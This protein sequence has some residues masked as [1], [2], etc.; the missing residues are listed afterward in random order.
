MTIEEFIGSIDNKTYNKI[1]KS[2]SDAE[3]R[4]YLKEH[5]R[6]QLNIPAVLSPVCNVQEGTR[7]SKSFPSYIDGKCRE[8]GGQANWLVTTVQEN[9]HLITN[10]EIWK[11]FK[12]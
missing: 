8:C 4:R 10:M 11:S 3:C 12:L 5:L 1:R 7:C 9:K 2:Q 6:K